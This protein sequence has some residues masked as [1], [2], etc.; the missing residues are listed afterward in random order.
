M[1]FAGVELTAESIKAAH[2]WYAD[3]A[4]GCIAE[5]ISGAVKLGARDTQAEYVENMASYFA[6]C[7][8]RAEMHDAHANGTARD[9]YRYSFAFL[10]RA[11][12]I[13]T[14][15]CIALLP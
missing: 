6:D 7:N 12:T 9:E 4:R 10:Q 3:N 5:V 1:K 8:A 14:G 11:H 15:E 2:A 13:Q